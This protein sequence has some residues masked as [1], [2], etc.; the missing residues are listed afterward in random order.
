[1]PELQLTEDEADRLLDAALICEQLGESH[2]AN[3]IR[4]VRDMYDGSG[5]GQRRAEIWNNFIW[6]SIGR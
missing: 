5:F 6:R 3:A 1:M 2:A 4:R